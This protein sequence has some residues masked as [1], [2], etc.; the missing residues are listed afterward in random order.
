MIIP[1][2]LECYISHISLPINYHELQTTHIC[3]LIASVD[4][5]LRKSS[6]GSSDSESLI[7]CNQDVIW[8]RTFEVSTVEKFMSKLMELLAGFSSSQAVELRVSVL[9]WLLA[10]G[11]L[12]SH[13][14]SMGL[15]SMADCCIKMCKSRRLQRKSARWIKPLCLP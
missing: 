3:F 15:S 12:P 11:L 7:D 6:A 2:T 9:C 8:L 1:C 5:V 4:L 10:R 14:W 13:P